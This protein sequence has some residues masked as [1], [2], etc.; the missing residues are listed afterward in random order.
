MSIGSLVRKRIAC[1]L[2]A[3]GMTLAALSQSLEDIAALGLPVM[4]IETIDGEMPDCDYVHHPSGNIGKSITN[5]TKV[6]GRITIKTNG[7]TVYDSGEFMEDVSGMRIRL[8]GNASAWDFNPKPYKIKLER[9]ADLLRRGDDDKYEDKNWLLLKELRMTAT[10][11]F[12]VSELAGLQWTPAFEHIN[13]IFNGKYMGV[14]LLMESVRRNRSC[15]LDVDDTG[16]IFEYDQYW[17]NEPLYVESS[18]KDDPIH[19]TFKY[20]EPEAISPAQLAY[21][22]EMIQ[23]TEQSID[24]GTYPQYIDLDSFAAWLLAHDIL[25]SWD[26]TGSN[27]FL[28]KYDDTSNSKLM[29]GNLWD[30][31]NSFQTFGEWDNSHNHFFFKKLFDPACENKAFIQAYIKKYDELSPKIFD[32]TANFI[33]EFRNSHKAEAISKSTDM[34]CDLFQKWNPGVDSCLIKALDWLDSRSVW[35]AHAVDSLRT[36]ASGIHAIQSD[37]QAE[38]V[39]SVDGRK[40]SR[41]KRGINI[42]RDRRGRTRKIIVK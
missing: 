8:R 28:T 27:I 23:K 20:P 42:V 18:I 17:W 19:Y 40:R 3:V 9:K 39:F 15:R 1:L 5:M 29:M 7:E 14:Y 34:E 12:K 36:E 10:V 2:T 4:E 25:G 26:G 31:D 22:T 32:E 33:E 11:G 30:I 13:V 35:M 38:Q 41:M 21:F 6:P 16:Y 37:T 24:D